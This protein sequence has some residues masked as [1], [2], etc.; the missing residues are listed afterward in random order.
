MAAGDGGDCCLHL[1]NITY[2]PCLTLVARCSLPV[3]AGIC[4]VCR[5][6]AESSRERPLEP[7]ESRLCPSPAPAPSRPFGH[8]TLSYTKQSTISS[9]CVCV[10]VRSLISISRA[11]LDNYVSVLMRPRPPPPSQDRGQSLSSGFAAS[12]FPFPTSLLAFAMCR[13]RAAHASN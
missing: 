11:Y 13:I 9:A 1:S 4:Q 2:T 10:C 3:G 6:R 8:N 7:R 12:H 5:P